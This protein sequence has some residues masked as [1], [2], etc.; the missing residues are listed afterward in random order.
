MYSTFPIGSL[1]VQQT[2]QVYA[3]GALL[4]Y[5]GNS[6]GPLYV[7][8]T[9]GTTYYPAAVYLGTIGRG[10]GSQTVVRAIDSAVVNLI[11]LA[12][13]LGDSGTNNSGGGVVTII[14]S[15]A[16]SQSDPGY[17]ILQL[18]PPAAVQAGA[19][20]KLAGQPASYYSK[21]NPS[22]QEITSTNSIVLQFKPI[23]G[24]NL[25]T[26]Q[27]VT[28][29]PGVIVTNTA[30]YTI[31]GANFSSASLSGNLL[32]MTFTAGA[33]QIYALERSTNL[34]TWTPLLTNT[35]PVGGTLNFS[36]TPSTNNSKSVFY[37]AHL[38]P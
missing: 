20:W 8:Y 30:L 35:V 3:T 14:P 27:S 5:P 21:A 38:V 10:L 34:N 17:L 9:N 2:N 24:W 28:V 13:A 36:D 29:F 19:A 16:V 1:L 25:P 18:G 37:R 22:L 6:G 15:L 32:A 12:A 7:Q 4:S 23:P 33:G 26:N 11:T 31:A